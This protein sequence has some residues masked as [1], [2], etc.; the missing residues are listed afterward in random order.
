MKIKRVTAVPATTPQGTTLDKQLV[1]NSE[2]E[3]MVGPLGFLCSA[4]NL[5]QVIDSGYFAGLPLCF[6]DFASGFF[7]KSGLKYHELNTLRQS[8]V[9]GGYQRQSRFTLSAAALL[10]LAISVSMQ[11]QGI[12]TVTPWSTVTTSAGTGAVGYTGDGG[13]AT[14]ATLAS[15]SA[16]AY[17][18]SGNLYLADAQNHVVREISKNG[19]ISTIAGTGIEGYS[20]DGTAATTA[21]LD[22][23]T[24]V[25]VDAAGNVYIADSHNHRIR[26]VSGGTI[27]TVAGTGIAGFSGD[28]NAATAAQLSLPSAVAVDSS[29]NVYIADTNN[30][31][32]R[33][34]TGTTI[35]TIAGEGE[36]LYAGDGA[37]ATAAVLDLPTGVAVD[38]SGNVY[39]ADRHNHRVRMITLAGTIS[40][41]AGS[42]I[43]SFSGGFSGDGASASAATL[44]KPSGVSVDGAGNIY[45]ADTDNQRVRQVSSGTVTTVAGSNQ[46][47]F[48]GDSGPATNAILNSPRA[49]A[50]DAYGN[51]TIADKLD[52]RLRMAAVP[53]LTFAS[54]GVGTSSGA[55]SV[56]VANTGSASITVAS[57]IFTGAFTTATG[58]SCSATPIT[59]APGANCTQ[60]VAFLPIAPGTANGSVLFGGTGIVPQSILLTGSSVQTAT[61]VTL[62][63]NIAS[64]FAGQSITF[65]ATVK[66]TGIGTPTGNVAFYD[67]TTL[68]GSSA[69]T[70]GSAS[71]AP[72]LIAGTHSITA[73]YTGDTNFTGNT[74]AVLSQLVLDFSFTLATTTSGSQ[75]VEPGQPANYTFTLMP[76][77]NLFTLPVALSATGLPPGAMATFTPQVVTIGASPA[78]FTMTI[79]T[80]ATAASRAPRLFFGTGYRDGTLVL[81]VLLLPFSRRMRRKVR[82]MRLLMLCAALVISL[83]AIGSLAGCG[84]GSGY[85][86]QPPQNYTINVIGTA[87]GSGGAALQHFTTVTLTVQ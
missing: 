70:A 30:Q 46:Q 37:A 13:A 56:T 29:G 60:N 18:A 54:A 42:G 55:Q 19:Q 8:E 62:T 69:L 50:S 61:T 10:L 85:F 68:I 78:S 82:S 27:A 76:V 84:S 52:E 47:G 38:A 33:K 66:P 21:L 63:S 2:A 49:A 65:T 81:G 28:G 43:P 57:I 51:L 16:V 35:T 53:T 73:V 24:G 45:I 15:P 87:T 86:A 23:P 9:V 75:T 58:G 36:E 22:T 12:L 5:Q 67:G 48:A 25:A 71:I 6:Q 31:R 7:G 74:S 1:V 83:S 72:V 4:L 34:I 79:Q 59:L 17:D 3:S 41:V 39:I 11:A 40:T 32:I 26:K 64:A 44:A 14:S 20:G 77:G 80:A